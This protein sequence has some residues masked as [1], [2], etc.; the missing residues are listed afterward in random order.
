M[1]KKQILGKDSGLITDCDKLESM[2]EITSVEEI[3]VTSTFFHK[4]SHSKPFNANCL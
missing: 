2:V 4:I 3:D 1:A